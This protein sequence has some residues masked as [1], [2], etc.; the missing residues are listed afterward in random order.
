MDFMDICNISGLGGNL[1]SN[2]PR[3]WWDGTE[4]NIREDWDICS[5]EQVRRW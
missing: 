3:D 2:N 1:N 4:I 5:E